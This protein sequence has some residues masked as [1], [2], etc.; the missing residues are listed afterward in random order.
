[1]SQ[2]VV[3]GKKKKKSFLFCL[4][5]GAGVHVT[6][7]P[8]SI[9]HTFP[10]SINLYWPR[11][12]VFCTGTCATTTVAVDGW[13]LP[14]SLTAEMSGV[15]CCLVFTSCFIFFLLSSSR[16]WL[17]LPFCLH[18][19]LIS[20]PCPDCLHLLPISL[21]VPLLW[22]VLPGSCLP[23][24]LL[25][26]VF[27]VW[28]IVRKVFPT[29]I[30]HVLLFICFSSLEIVFVYTFEINIF[31]IRFRR[32]AVESSPLSRSLQSGPC[33]DRQISKGAHIVAVLRH[34]RPFISLSLTH[35]WYIHWIVR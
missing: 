28:K 25:P 10:Q 7:E 3:S 27:Q 19:C 24:W 1:M 18:T 29:S 15:S 22:S 31:I 34:C 2:N 21:P 32:R 14:D 4:Q 33:G 20:I 13:D 35:E 11:V 26:I 17:W 16:A 8:P 5:D 9:P 6:N 12:R 30:S 23:I